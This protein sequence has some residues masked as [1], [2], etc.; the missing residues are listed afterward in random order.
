MRAQ[1]V[2][3]VLAAMLWLVPAQAA[4][5][6][7]KPIRIGG[8]SYSTWQEY[9]QSDQFNK[10]AGRGCGTPQILDEDGFQPPSDCSAGFTNPNPP[11]Y[12]PGEVCR[13]PVA[14][15]ILHSASGTGNIDESFILSQM[16]IFNEDF[17][18]I[19]GTPGG[20]GTD[21]TIEFV[22]D[23]ITRSSNDFWFN[24][25]PDPVEGNYYDNLAV[26]PHNYLNIY[27]CVPMGAGGVILGYV[28]DFPQSGGYVGTNEDRVVILHSSIGRDSP[29]P[30]Y[31]QG[32]TATHEVGHYLG[33]YHPFQGACGTTS[34]PGCYSTG[35]RICDTPGD[36][37]S[38]GGCPV[39][40]NSCPDPGLDPV[41]NYMEY[42]DD[43]CMNQFTPEQT[44]RARCTLI[45]YRPQACDAVTAVLAGSSSSLARFQLAQNR[46]NPFSPNTELNFQ[47]AREGRVSLV[48]MDVNGRAVRT[49]ATGILPQGSHRFEWNG[50]D[51]Q[52]ATLASGVYFY[53]LETEQGSETRRMVLL[54]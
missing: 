12:A 21:T 28:A 50:T 8:Q 34:P 36:A 24:D 20:P 42:T 26:D 48:V 51:D 5:D 7:K 13:I 31:H 30:P 33:L 41:H 37:E 4:G 43:T 52:K 23:R 27:S 1:V 39:T 35:D 15:H 29:N 38:H 45:H 40:S 2:L 53:R 49:L 19:P 16:E 18:A 32:R 22:L 9:L 10:Q 3:A 44:R 54:R 47:L 17:R 14:F 6:A 11:E 46:P 25:L